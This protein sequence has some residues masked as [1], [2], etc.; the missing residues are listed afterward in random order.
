MASA[1]R[2]GRR[3]WGTAGLIGTA[4]Y[5]TVLGSTQVSGKLPTYPSP[6]PTFAQGE[7]QMLTLI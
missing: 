7:K 2:G 4:L 1:S 6:N 5:C 3:Y